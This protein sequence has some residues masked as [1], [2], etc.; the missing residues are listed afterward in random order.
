MTDG[1]NAR[2]IISVVRALPVRLP[3]NRKVLEQ[4]ADEL[5]GKAPMFVLLPRQAVH[6]HAGAAFWPGRHDAD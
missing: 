2:Q 1:R 5:A 3:R 6:A 4:L